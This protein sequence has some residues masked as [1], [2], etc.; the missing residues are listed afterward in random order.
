[1]PPRES[2]RGSHGDGGEWKEGRKRVGR[3]VVVGGGARHIVSEPVLSS[4]AGREECFLRLARERHRERELFCAPLSSRFARGVEVARHRRHSRPFPP[5]SSG[6]DRAA[7][8][9]GL[10]LP[11]LGGGGETK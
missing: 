7:E 2:T 4:V 3:E 10:V 8:P 5:C 1:M 11:S 6:A 9:G